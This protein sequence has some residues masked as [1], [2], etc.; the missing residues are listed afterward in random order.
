MMGRFLGGFSKVPKHQRFN[1]IPRHYDPIKDELEQRVRSKELDSINSKEA[2]RYRIQEGIR[3]NQSYTK[4]RSEST[5]RSN[6]IIV[7]LVAALAT[8]AFLLLGNLDTLM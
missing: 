1:Y 6:V 2:R 5:L 8:M 7:A 3:R 4:T